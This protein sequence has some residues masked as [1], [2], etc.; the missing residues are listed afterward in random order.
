ML[1]LI[2]RKEI[3]QQIHIAEEIQNNASGD[4]VDVIVA[5]IMIES[6]GKWYVQHV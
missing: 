3:E 5:E 6:V 4:R 1:A 2:S